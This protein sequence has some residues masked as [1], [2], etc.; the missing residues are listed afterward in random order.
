VNFHK[1]QL[2]GINVQHTW[3]LDAAGTLNC[4]VGSFPTKYLGV[5]IGGDPRKS[6]T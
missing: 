1:S 5:P 4:K 6:G 3:L 2:I